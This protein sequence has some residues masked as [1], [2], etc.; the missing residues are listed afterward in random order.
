[1]KRVQVN[2]CVLFLLGLVSEASAKDRTVKGYITEIN[3]DR[4]ALEIWKNRIT[5]P[6]TVGI[7]IKDNE[8]NLR[9][10]LKDLRIGMYVEAACTYE[11]NKYVLTALKLIVDADQFE[12]EIKITA[13][14]HQNLEHLEKMGGGWTGHF[15]LDGQRVRIAP[16]TEVVFKLNREEQNV[17]KKIE[18]QIKTAASSTTRT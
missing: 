12:R 6:Q 18:R 4:T 3:A 17:A 13:Y 8:K 2:L 11:K 9:L 14:L 5:V 16:Q 15:F 1:M 10:G 7:E